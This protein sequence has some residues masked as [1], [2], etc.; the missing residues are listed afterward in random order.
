MRSSKP[1]TVTLGEMQ[2][3]V[4]ARVRS[5]GYASVSEVVRAG[6][7]ALEREEAAVE[8]ALARKVQEALDDPGQPLPA[9]QVFA[10]LR[11]H[12]QGRLNAAQDG[13]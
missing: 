9:D 11:A 13:D 6:L 12:H 5:G 2:E 10:E 1:V 4:E 3:R 8:N 7:R